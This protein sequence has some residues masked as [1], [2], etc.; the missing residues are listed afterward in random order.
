MVNLMLGVFYH[1]KKLSLEYMK[2]IPSPKKVHN[3]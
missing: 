3:M 2:N 1:N